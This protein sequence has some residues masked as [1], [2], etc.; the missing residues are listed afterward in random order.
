MSHGFYSQATNPNYVKIVAPE[1]EQ[2]DVVVPKVWQAACREALK[3]E[4]FSI[5]SAPCGSGKSI[6]ILL[7]AI[8][9]ILASHFTQ[10]SLTICPMKIIGASF[11]E[12]LKVKIGD[13]IWTWMPAHDF[14]DY[15]HSS[16]V[17]AL[18]KWLLS[19]S[20]SL[21]NPDPSDPH[22]IEGVNAVCSHQ[23]LAIVWRQLTKTE[24]VIA[25][26][27]LTLNIDEC[28]HISGVF[29]E[30]NG[31]ISVEEKEESNHL[32]SVVHAVVNSPDETARICLG[33]ATFFRN[34]SFI[35]HK[36]AQDQFKTFTYPWVE[37][38]PSLNI[39]SFRMEYRFY[40]KN[41]DPIEQA[42]A[43]I[44]NDEDHIWLVYLP[45]TGCAWRRKKS[46]EKFFEKLYTAVPKEQVLDLIT[47]NTQRANTKRFK[48]DVISIKKGNPPKWKVLAAVGVGLEGLD[49][50]PADRLINLAVPNSIVRA[51]QVIGRPMRRYDKKV[52]VKVFNYISE[53]VRVK[54][55]LTLHELL[56]D[57]TNA[58]L[59]SM[60]FDEMIM[61]TMVMVPV[62]GKNDKKVKKELSDAVGYDFHKLMK[63]ILVAV[64]QEE[65]KSI[66]TITT[67]VKDVLADAGIT[68]DAIIEGMVVQVIK[69]LLKS[70][71]KP[72]A[73]KLSTFFDVS[74]LR[75]SGL[76]IIK[77]YELESGTIFFGDCG[78]AE[79]K[80]VRAFM[81]DNWTTMFAAAC[82]AQDA[83]LL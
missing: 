49:Y 43:H 59:V 21:C 8:D 14:I 16:V 22:K 20:K 5:I 36:T 83:G 52:D 39:K 50:P 53:F 57:R 71:K 68:D 65:N 69:A 11:T 81:L 28:H 73:Q 34:T 64:E 3:G 15:K 46:L 29:D 70:H 80:A 40:K 41:G 45:P 18:K 51:L 56:S 7:R 26:H 6:A 62:L 35:L 74:M 67:I 76:D 33:T 10:R 19:D 61:P 63:S 47:K 82:A 72:S 37:H 78:C 24:K 23:A 9:E 58:L 75:K 25:I 12:P 1:K 66:E 4:R 44:K 31:E 54:K 13:E 30:T 48:D 77:K 79:L 42:I 2:S 27:N 38:F 55:D 32:G 17:A 60:T